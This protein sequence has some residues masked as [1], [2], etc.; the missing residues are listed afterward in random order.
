MAVRTKRDNDALRG[1]EEE[2]AAVEQLAVTTVVEG[3]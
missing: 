1:D 2:A 3:G